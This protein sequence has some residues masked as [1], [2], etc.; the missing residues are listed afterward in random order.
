MTHLRSITEALTPA[1][2]SRTLPTR[3][4]KRTKKTKKKIKKKAYATEYAVRR[5]K[6]R[7]PV[8]CSPSSPRGALCNT[9]S[10]ELTANIDKITSAT[11]DTSPHIIKNRQ[12][13]SCLISGGFS[14]PRTL[15]SP[16]LPACTAPTYPLYLYGCA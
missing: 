16:Q 15:K 4:N 12:R 11:S 1:S 7:L 14:L 5:D 13:K 3:S 6:A 2:P 8:H 9:S 10:L